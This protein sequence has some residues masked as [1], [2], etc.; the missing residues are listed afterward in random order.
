[1][2]VQLVGKARPFKR[3]IRRGLLVLVT[4]ALLGFLT[5]LGL[6]W[7][8]VGAASGKIYT[9]VADVPAAPVALVLGAG[10]GS[11]YF[12]YRLD[13][14]V[15]LYKAGKVSHFLVS[16]NGAA[17]DP[18]G[19]ET[20]LMMQGLLHRG[21]PAAAITRDD[22][23]LRTLDS[24]A[25]AHSVFRLKSIVIVTQEFHLPRALYLA[26]AW[27]LDAVGFAATDPGG[28]FYDSY[29]REWLARVKAVAD[30]EIL[31]TPPQKLGPSTPITLE[32]PPMKPAAVF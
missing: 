4:L 31:N 13:A 32:Q 30:E 10:P 19:S 1:M 27:G 24:M 20:A 15:A 11:L 25:R 17:L 8:L 16:G 9:R 6:N 21:I 2:S 12:N 28:D 3:L 5:V 18:M 22:Y 7:W 23:G 14:A 26:R 29:L